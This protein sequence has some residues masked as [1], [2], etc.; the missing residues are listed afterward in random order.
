M[1]R[2]RRGIKRYADMLKS[3]D[4]KRILRAVM[5]SGLPF[6][7]VE[8]GADYI[9]FYAPDDKPGKAYDRWKA[10]YD[11]RDEEDFELK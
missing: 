7:A 3:T 5:D 11:R 9:R 6:G 8:I 1:W 2:T 10:Q 4:I